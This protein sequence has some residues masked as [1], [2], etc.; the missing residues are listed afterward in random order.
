MYS[1]CHPEVQNLTTT[2]TDI[3]ERERPDAIQTNS[4]NINLTQYFNNIHALKYDNGLQLILPKTQLA[5][6]MGYKLQSTS[7]NVPTTAKFT[8]CKKTIKNMS[9]SL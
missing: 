4:G 9:S 2:V 1:L 6:F 8:T 7:M 3:T 5:D